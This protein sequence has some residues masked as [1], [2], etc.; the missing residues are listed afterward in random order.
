MSALLVRLAG[1]MQSWGVQSRFTIRDTG[2]EPSKSGVIGLVCA[3]LGRPRAAPLDDL[4]A[5]RMG[6]RCDREGRLERDYHTAGGTR[7]GREYG[8]RKADGKSAD[9]VV[10]ERFYLADADFLVGLEGDRLLLDD[11]DAHLL[12]PHWP[13]SLGRK[14]FVP[15]QAVRVGV[16]DEALEPALGRVPWQAR[17]VREAADVRAASRRGQPHQL[18]L[19]LDATAGPDTE[20][21]WDVP[22]SFAG[23]ARHFALRHIRMTFM[24]LDESLITEP[25]HVPLP[26]RPQS[27]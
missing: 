2:L 10:S 22:L 18:R 9:T 12:R 27:A 5:L 17:T 1:P 21:R 8:V 6:V 24:P 13:L 15:A 7:P 11:I 23:G 3:A 19:V 26:S 25:D 20:T 14:A 16:R 4:A